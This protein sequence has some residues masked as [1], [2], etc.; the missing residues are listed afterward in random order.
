[1]SSQAVQ[2]QIGLL[3]PERMGI[4]SLDRTAKLDYWLVDFG[5]VAALIGSIIFFAGQLL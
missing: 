2:S 3:N 5:L 4:Q 1:M